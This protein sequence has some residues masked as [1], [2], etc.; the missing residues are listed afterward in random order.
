MPLFEIKNS[1]ELGEL[2]AFIQITRKEIKQDEDEKPEQIIIEKPKK[3]VKKDGEEG[4]EN[5]EEEPPEEENPDGVPK[6]KPENFTWTSYDGNPRNY[7][8]VLKRLKMFPVKVVKS[9]NCRDEL[10]KAIKEH[11]NNFGKKEE[12]KYNGMISIINVGDNIPEETNKIVNDLCNI[13]V[14]NEEVEEEKEKDK[15]KENKEQDKEKEK[16]K[17]E[18][19]NNKK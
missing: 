2:T 7:V 14:I 4:E 5:A 8:Q 9:D 16:E 6:F 10:I 13:D 3:E 11:L 1:L 17:E 12:N 15:E 19:K 18:D